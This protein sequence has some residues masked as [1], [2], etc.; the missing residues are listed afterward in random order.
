MSEWPNWNKE[1]NMTI[2]FKGWRENI[3]HAPQNSIREVIKKL[4]LQ[5]SGW[6]MTSKAYITMF[7]KN[8]YLCLKL[9][10]ICF[11]IIMEW[12]K[13][14]IPSVKYKNYSNEVNWFWN[15]EV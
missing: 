5:C 10:E 13:W 1:G 14:S 3:K 6:E 12:Q 2:K 9:K 15:P 4:V 8:K 11:T 7:H